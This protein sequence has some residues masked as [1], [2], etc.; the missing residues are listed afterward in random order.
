MLITS[1][2]IWMSARRS[3]KKGSTDTSKYPIRLSRY[4]PVLCS[5]GF[6]SILPLLSGERKIKVMN[7]TKSKEECCISA[8][9]PKTPRLL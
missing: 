8:D 1:I 3:N 2:D 7:H 4:W 5:V 9:S 6:D